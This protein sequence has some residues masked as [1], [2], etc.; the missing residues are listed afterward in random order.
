MKERKSKSTKSDRAVTIATFAITIALIVIGFWIGNNIPIKE[1]DTTGFEDC[2]KVAQEIVDKLNVGILEKPEGYT[3]EELSN[4][5][6]VGKEGYSGYVKVTT[7]KGNL[8][9]ENI[10]S[11]SR[12]RNGVIGSAITCAIA[13]MIFYLGVKTS[14]G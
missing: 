4:G 14:E 13:I 6:M 2:T 7:Q 9:Y 1:L 12:F 11:N 10:S 8:L 5:I 3:V